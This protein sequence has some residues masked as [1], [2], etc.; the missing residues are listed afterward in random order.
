MKNHP[1][2]WDPYSCQP[3]KMRDEDKPRS[4]LGNIIEYG[5][6]TG[7]NLLGLPA[8]AYQYLS[9]KKSPANIAAGNF[10]GLSIAPDTEYQAAIQEMVAELGVRQLLLR[11]P[12]WDTARLCAV[13]RIV[14]QSGVCD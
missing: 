1:D 7:S 10:V 11:I 12:T 13:S 6:V 3:Y 2:W 14:S 5:K 4:G 9:L 8:I